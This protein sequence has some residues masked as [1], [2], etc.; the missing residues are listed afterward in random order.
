MSETIDPQHFRHVLGHFPTGVAAVTS[1]DSAGDPVGM[2]VGSFTS[3]SLDPPLVAFLPAKSSSTAP[4][5]VNSGRFCVNVLGAHQEPVSR[6]F[7]TGGARKFDEVGWSPA[8]DNGLPRLSDAIAWI[9]CAVE[10]VHDVG[11]HQIV[12]GRVTALDAP[13]AALPLLFFQSG[14]G[15]FAPQS[16]AAAAEPD[17]IEHLR[18]VDV[19]RP[20][21]EETATRHGVECHA[22]SAVGDEIV[23]LATAGKPAG[24][25]AFSRVGQRLPHVPPLGTALVAWSQ[26]ATDAWIGRA[27]DSGSEAGSGSEPG[28]GSEA[29]EKRRGFEQLA[30]RVR[31]R[32]FSVATWSENLRNL[33]ATVDDTTLA[34]L[35]PHGRRAVRQL[36]EQLGGEHEPDDIR[37]PRR[38]YSLRNLT[39]PVFDQRRDVVM[40]LTFYGLP[41]GPAHKDLDR[42]LEPLTALAERVSAAL[43]A[44][45]GARTAAAPEKG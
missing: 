42:Y 37:D 3:V 8:P 38:D 5:I 31:E 44:T 9:E 18:L 6:A 12:I 35:T 36:V 24:G 41:S 13:G 16:F 17:L 29:G 2:I 43:G 34:G 20:H 19:A 7:T 23:L 39:V 1:L 22:S 21:M 15:R 45:A 4:K 32:G 25:R 27:P 33:E 26:A 10:A 14:Y 30:A 11:D 40:Q 28:A